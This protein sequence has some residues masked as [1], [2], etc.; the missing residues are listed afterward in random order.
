MLSY[1]SLYFKYV[2]YLN[3]AAKQKSPGYVPLKS[4]KIN[5]TNL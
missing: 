3:K 5:N 4:R 1:Q 2:Q